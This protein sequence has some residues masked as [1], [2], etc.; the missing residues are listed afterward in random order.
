M[1]KDQRL[2]GHHSNGWDWSFVDVSEGMCIQNADFEYQK[3]RQEARAAVY[4]AVQE[5]WMIRP[6]VC[7]DC[8]KPPKKGIIEAHH[9][10]YDSDKWYDVVWLCKS[11]HLTGHGKTRATPW[12]SNPGF[13]G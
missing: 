11:C 12:V 2:D 13:E 6:E 1:A 3:K 5:G 10:S 7:S 9:L 4:Q 8:G